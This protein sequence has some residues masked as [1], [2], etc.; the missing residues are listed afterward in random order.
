[1]AH[2]TQFV[3]L[4]LDLGRLVVKLILDLATD[5]VDNKRFNVDL[6][7][8]NPLYAIFIAPKTRTEIT[9][10]MTQHFSNKFKIKD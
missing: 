6:K 3:K 7:Y 4:K 10:V 9:V 5:I 2:S 8:R 1:M